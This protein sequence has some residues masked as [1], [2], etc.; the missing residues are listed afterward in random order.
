M[1]GWNKGQTEQMQAIYLIVYQLVT[2]SK[3]IRLFRVPIETSGPHDFLLSIISPS[4]ESFEP[5]WMK[6]GPEF[7][8]KMILIQEDVVPKCIDYCISLLEAEV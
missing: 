8:F 1:I 2:L 6:S 5:D 4:T 7:V 3:C